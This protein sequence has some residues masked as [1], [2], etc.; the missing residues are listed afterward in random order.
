M[1]TIQLSNHLLRNAMRSNAIFSGGSGFV[2][3]VA[4]GPLATFLGLPQG[5]RLALLIIGVLLISHGIILWFSAGNTPI[6][7]MA[8]WY[9]IIGDIGWVVGSVA[10]LFIDPWQFTSGGWWLVAIL[11]DIVAI[12]AVAQYV[13]LRRADR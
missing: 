13:G 7:P 5:G 10:I 3:A 2:A 12:F 4:A 11:A 8:A 6:S 9:A 1:A